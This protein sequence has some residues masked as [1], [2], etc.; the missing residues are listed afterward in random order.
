M[1]KFDKQ[2]KKASSCEPAI[3]YCPAISGHRFGC[4]LRYECAIA[5]G[6]LANQLPNLDALPVNGVPFASSLEHR[7]GHL[8]VRHTLDRKGPQI[9]S[10]LE[11][12]IRK[13]RVATL[14]SQ[15]DRRGVNGTECMEDTK[16]RADKVRGVERVCS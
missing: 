14:K 15:I 2:C 1:R 6:R 13:T 10:F 11:G 12:V 7:S 5:S 9:T 8:F 3:L 4:D 16:Q